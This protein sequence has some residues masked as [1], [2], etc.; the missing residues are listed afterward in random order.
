MSIGS[1]IKKLRRE[2]EMTQEQLAEC[3]GITANAVS[4]WECDRTAPDI[5]QLPILARILQVTTDRLLGIDF[6]KD[7]QEIQRISEESFACY[8]TGQFTKS[9]EIARKGLQ[10]YPR[11]YQLMARLAESLLAMKGSE[12]EMERLCDKILKECTESS[13]RD[14]AYRLKIILYGK[15]GKYDEIMEMANDLPHIWVSQEET[16]MRWN[17]STDEERRMELIRFA[18]MYMESLTTCLDKIARLPCYT[19]EEQIRIRM[20]II[21]MMQ[22]MYPEKD[23]LSQAAIMASQYYVIASLYV[24]SGE[25]DQAL[26]ALE[27]VCEYFK[28]C[29]CHDGVHISLVFR[30]CNRGKMHTDER[31]YCREFMELISHDSSFEPLRED[32]RYMEIMK[33]LITNKSGE[34]R[35]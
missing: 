29:D 15:Q 6:S 12:K 35:S 16:R 26:I 33:K 31:S 19:A 34:K 20:Q 14:H 8:R 4:Q 9:V 7:E 5:S 30:G 11:S 21:N 25:H 17:F 3:L 28:Y 10:Q 24:N 27:K 18:K 22:T 13:P 32:P 2:Q 1:T 23:Y